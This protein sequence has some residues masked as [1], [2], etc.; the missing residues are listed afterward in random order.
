LRK[1]WIH[2][3]L[4]LEKKFHSIRCLSWRP[5]GTVETFLRRGLVPDLSAVNPVRLFSL[6]TGYV[7]LESS[8]I[9]PG[10]K[11]ILAAGSSYSLAIRAKGDFYELVCPCY[12]AGIENGEAWLANDK[13]DSEIPVGWSCILKDLE[14]FTLI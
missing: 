14:T 11:A 4:P 8:F 10:D 7:G 1:Y 3:T 5:Q 6:N 12:I 2:S 13:T 9:Y